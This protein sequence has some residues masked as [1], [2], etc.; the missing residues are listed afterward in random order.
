M[1]KV[2]IGVGIVAL[3]GLVLTV[4]MAAAAYASKAFDML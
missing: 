2:L 1:V 4:G 3:I